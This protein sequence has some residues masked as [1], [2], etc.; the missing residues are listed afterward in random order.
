MTPAQTR[1]HGQVTP[2]LP[3]PWL[4]AML[5]V[6]AEFVQIVVSTFRMRLRRPP[7]NGTWSLPQPPPGKKTD[8]YKETI[9]IAARDNGSIVLKLRRAAKL[10]ISQYEGVLTTMSHTSPSS[11]PCFATNATS[12]ETRQLFR[13]DAS[14]RSTSPCYAGG[15]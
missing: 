10:R 6:V 14:H 8:T 7:V 15:V 4:A 1:A 2:S 11:T 13:I 12:P 9:P 3:P 5:R